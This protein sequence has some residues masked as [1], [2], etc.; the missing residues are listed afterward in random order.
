MQEIKEMLTKEDAKTLWT[1]YKETSDS[2]SEANDCAVRA[3]A[4]VTGKPY[5][6]VNQWL[7]AGGYRQ[8]RTG[9]SKNPYQKYLEHC[10][11][12]SRV[13]RVPA[14]TIR[15]FQQRRYQGKF[16]VR[17]RGHILAV[18]DGQAIDWADMRLHRIKEVIQV[19]D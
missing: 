19:A 3:L 4:A 2:F 15:S 9:T 10:G 5:S 17:V 16:L 7:I 11:I 12:A 1:Q 8:P 13:V 18:I 6:E 14:K